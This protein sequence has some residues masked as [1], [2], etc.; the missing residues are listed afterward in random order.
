MPSP[1]NLGFRTPERQSTFIA[2]EREYTGGHEAEDCLIEFL[3]KNPFIAEVR[4]ADQQT[5]EQG[6]V[7]LLIRFKGREDFMKF[8][9]YV[10]NNP[11][12]AEEKKASLPRNDVYF[13]WESAGILKDALK[14]YHEAKKSGEENIHPIDFITPRQETELMYQIISSMPKVQQRNVLG[15]LQAQKEAL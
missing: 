13:V 10:G 14:K 9:L 4:H 1:G 8:Q 15:V 5:D 7:D 3:R 6:K 12:K 11:N 2:K